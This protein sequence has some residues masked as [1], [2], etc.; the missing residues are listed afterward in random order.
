VSW[1]LDELP[2][3]QSGSVELVAV[4]IEPGEHKLRVAGRAQRGLADEVLQ[5]VEVEGLAAVLFTVVDTADPIEVEGETM[6]EIKVINQGSKA[7]TN[8]QIL[9]QLP[10]D[11][12]AV[13]AT[14]PTRQQIEPGRVI[15]AP[16]GRLAPKAETTYQVKVQALRAGDQRIR[17]QLTSDDIRTPVT[18]EEST[19]VYADE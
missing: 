14:G 1:G 17:V 13:S 5:T 16:L 10:P 3:K 15:F 7:S 6:Y 11:L 18:K 8:V 2:A 4:P 9:V 12:K 19:R